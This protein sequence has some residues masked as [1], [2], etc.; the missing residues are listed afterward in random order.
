MAFNYAELTKIKNDISNDAT[1]LSTKL[2]N[3][4][5]LIADNVNN[6]KVWNSD[7]SHAFKEEWDNFENTDFPT[8]KATFNKEVSTL[9]SFINA[10][11]QAEK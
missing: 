2:S 1:S 4:S 10:W 11:Q 3:F 6:K 7:T 5:E 9:E 8:Y